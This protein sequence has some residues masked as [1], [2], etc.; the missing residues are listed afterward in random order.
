MR[1]ARSL[2]RTA[3]QASRYSTLPRGS[4]TWTA[5]SI[6]SS[7]QSSIPSSGKHLKRSCTSSEW[8]GS[9]RAPV[10]VTGTMMK[11]NEATGSAWQCRNRYAV[12][13]PNDVTLPGASQKPPSSA[14]SRVAHTNLSRAVSTVDRGTGSRANSP[15]NPQRANV[16]RRLRK[17]QTGRKWK[18]GGH[19]I[20]LLPATGGR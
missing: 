4:A 13:L 8:D 7:T 15:R 5:S 11:R 19:F 20:Y 9:D 6:L 10:V 17:R 12:T 3:G 1:C 16:S 14:G 2:T 18:V